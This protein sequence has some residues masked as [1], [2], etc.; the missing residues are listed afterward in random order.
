MKP[1]GAGAAAVAAVQTGG[2]QEGAGEERVAEAGGGG[3]GPSVR[4]F[5]GISPAYGN[6]QKD[7]WLISKF[8]F[9]LGTVSRVSNPNC[10]LPQWVLGGMADYPAGTL[11]TT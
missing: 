8:D 4:E 5:G 7:E 1:P 3:G 9:P 2:R 11:K 10:G 6:N